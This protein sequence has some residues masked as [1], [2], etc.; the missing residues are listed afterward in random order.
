M[1]VLFDSGSIART[2]TPDESDHPETLCS[3]WLAKFLERETIRDLAGHGD[4]PVA[5]RI[6]IPSDANVDGATKTPT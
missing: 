6:S 4:G 1:V 2:S 3:R 5:T